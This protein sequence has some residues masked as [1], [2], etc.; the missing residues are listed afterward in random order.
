M[1]ERFFSKVYF[2]HSFF[3]DVVLN[4]L[5]SYADNLGSSIIAD[6]VL[7][8]FFLSLLVGW[9]SGLTMTSLFL[10]FDVGNA[11]DDIFDAA[12]NDD[13]WFSG[14][15]MTSLFLV[16]DVGDARD[17]VF[18][19]AN[20]DDGDDAVVVIE[21]QDGMRWLSVLVFIFVGDLD[22]IFAAADNDNE[23]ASCK[24][25]ANDQEHTVDAVEVKGDTSE[26]IG[27][28]PLDE[29]VFFFWLFN[30]DLPLLFLVG[31]IFDVFVTANNDDGGD[32][33]DADRG[34]RESWGLANQKN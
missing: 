32:W 2:K 22:A 23:D 15:T 34:E 9:F 18:K 19:A 3:N 6:S 28:I 27:T 29:L 7:L 1:T 12:N 13:G 24:N 5:T 16:F 4:Q 25:T 10:V 8:V 11:R 31:D 30:S 20:N 33:L 14:L 17:G 21:G 26:T